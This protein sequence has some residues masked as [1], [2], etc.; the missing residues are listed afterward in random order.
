MQ[1]L[2]NI[3]ILFMLFFALILSAQDEK[4]IEFG[5]YV[6]AG[7]GYDSYI[8]SLGKD[9][10]QRLGS[11]EMTIDAGL[12]LD[13]NDFFTNIS[14]YTD[15]LQADD[16]S[17]SSLMSFLSAGWAR[18]ID[19]YDLSLS[20]S[21][22]FTAYD[23]QDLRAYYG[24]AGAEFEFFFNHAQNMSWYFNLSGAYTRGIDKMLSYLRGPSVNFDTGEYFYFGEFDSSIRINYRFSALFYDDISAE[25]YSYLGAMGISSLTGKNTGVESSA[26]INGRFNLKELY[27]IA[28]LEYRNLTM[29]GRD[30]W[31]YTDRIVKKRRVDHT[32]SVEVEPGWEPS[33]ELTVNISY[34]FEKNFSTLGKNDYTDENYYRHVIKLLVTYEF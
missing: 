26:G 2:K 12:N 15:A 13:I 24:D 23:F 16:W 6:T 7:G 29:L 10:S 25:N 9:P 22:E 14:F 32:I 27:I 5:G 11:Y 3:L 4:N 1:S 21:G 34:F 30:S 19:D 8:P 33:E 17:H 18:S 31:E 28:D 20:L